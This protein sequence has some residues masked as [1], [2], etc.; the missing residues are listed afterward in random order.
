MTPVAQV[1]AIAELA[2]LK[3]AGNDAKAVI[4]QSLVRGWLG[5]FPL[6]G[7]HGER[8]NVEEARSILFGNDKDAIDG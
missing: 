4:A 5:L 2:K 3:D 7:K 8:S 6:G 1:M